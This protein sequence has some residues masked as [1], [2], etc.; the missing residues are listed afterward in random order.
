MPCVVMH[1]NLEA[2][3]IIELLRHPDVPNGRRQKFPVGTLSYS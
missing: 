2:V 1:G 3:K